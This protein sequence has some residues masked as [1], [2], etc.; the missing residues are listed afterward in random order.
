MT[1][2]CIVRHGETEWN[3]IGR[4]QGRSDIPLNEKGIKQAEESGE[5][6]KNSQWDVIITSPLQRA[7]KTAEIINTYINVPL[8]VMDDFKEKSF[9][10]AEGMTIEEI[11]TAFPDRNYTNQES[12]D[13]LIKR[14]MGGLEK[15]KYNYEDKNVLLVAHGAVINAILAHLSDGELGYGKSRIDNACLNDIHFEENGWIIKA[16]NR[17][18]HLSL[19]E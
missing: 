15:I 9:G 17:V 18:E 7:K 12:A 2:I 3:A 10:D 4:L 19:D 16:Y 8:V 11:R 6:L 13:A 5:Y 1:K 14:L